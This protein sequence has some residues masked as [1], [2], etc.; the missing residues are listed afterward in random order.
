MVDPPEESPRLDRFT[1]NQNR[2]PYFML[3]DYDLGGVAVRDE[4]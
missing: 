1:A 2:S 3:H 4:W